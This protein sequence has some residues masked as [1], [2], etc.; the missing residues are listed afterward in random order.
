MKPLKI[1]SEECAG[2]EWNL[3]KFSKKE[4]LR[5]ND[6]LT[7]TNNE[8]ETSIRFTDYK[9]TDQKELDDDLDDNESTIN[10]EGMNIQITEEEDYEVDLSIARAKEIHQANMTTLFK[11]K[12]CKLGEIEIST[13]EKHFKEC[14]FRT[15]NYGY[16]QEESDDGTTRS[17]KEFMETASSS[18]S[19]FQKTTPITPVEY[20]IGNLP[21]HRVF[22]QDPTTEPEM[23]RPI[24]IRMPIEA[25]IKLQDGGDRG[26]ILNIAAHDP[27]LWNSVI[28]VWKGIVVAD[29]IHHY[30][31][32]NAK[33]MYRYMETFLGESIK[34]VW[35]AYK[36]AYPQE[37][38]KLVNMGPN[39]YNF[40]NK[41]HSLIT[42]EDPNSGLVVL[43]KNAL[44]KLEQLSITNWSHIKNFLKDY[45]YYCA[46]SG[47]AFDQR[48]GK[49]LFNKLPGALGREI[50]ERWSKREGVMQNPNAS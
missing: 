6:H 16:R 28:D 46:I 15:D 11:C 34:G 39:P 35:E 45:F 1:N 22:R 19:P 26:K 49:K 3:E 7:Y 48:L 17:L 37:F 40:T 44:I 10:M 47:N 4:M 9:Y 42:G 41:I 25:P 14:K 20:T 43:Q 27:Q 21:R 32:T 50:E 8:G 24:G 13:V 5:P 36:V 30:S 2:R 31:E 33:T 12:G 23:V 18:S 29:Y 38:Q